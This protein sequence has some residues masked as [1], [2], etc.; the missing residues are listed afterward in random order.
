M[1]YVYAA[2]Q[3]LQLQNETVESIM[4]DDAAML[5]LVIKVRCSRC[6]L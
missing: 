3:G 2:D 1:A 6:L 4:Y 5:L